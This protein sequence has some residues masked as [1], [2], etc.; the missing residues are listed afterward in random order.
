LTE[1]EDEVIAPDYET[2][3]LMSSVDQLAIEE[4]QP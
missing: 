3:G 4:K 2:L 1:I